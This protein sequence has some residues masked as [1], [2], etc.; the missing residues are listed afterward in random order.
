MPGVWPPI[1][2]GERRYMDGG[3]RSVTNADLAEGYDQ[4]L[5]VAPMSGFPNSPLGPTLDQETEQLATSSKVHVVLGDEAAVAAF[6]TNPLDP[7]TRVPSARAGRSQ[8]GATLEA[9]RAFWS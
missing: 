5:V 2:I 3:M 1:T 9:V 6:G 8:A 4:V 7:A